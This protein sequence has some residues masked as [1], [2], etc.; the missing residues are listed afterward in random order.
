MFEGGPCIPETITTYYPSHRLPQ[1]KEEKSVEKEV[2]DETEDVYDNVA[3]IESCTML[4]HE[5]LKALT[6]DNFGTIFVFG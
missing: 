6:F 1:V 2:S 5:F 4:W 3:F